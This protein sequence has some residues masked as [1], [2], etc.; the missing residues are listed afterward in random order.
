MD[1][2]VA[3]NR[4]QHVELLPAVN[5]DFGGIIVEMKEPMEPEAFRSQL[6]SSISLWKLQVSLLLIFMQE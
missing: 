3:E 6:R 4:F 2:G 1:Q 5:D